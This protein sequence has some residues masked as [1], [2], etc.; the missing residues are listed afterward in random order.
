MPYAILNKSTIGIYAVAEDDQHRD[1]FD[2]RFYDKISIPQSNFND[3]VLG[4]TDII[5]TDNGSTFSYPDLKNGPDPYELNET[6]FNSR[7]SDLQR[8]LN[9][10][11]ANNPDHP[12]Y[13]RAVNYLDS[14]KNLN[15]DNITFPLSVT[16]EEYMDQ[17]NIDFLHPYQIR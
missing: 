12:I 17:Q 14:L 1:A 9:Q 13:N 5:T 2:S 10:F 4:K 6:E 3:V 16:F 15:L 11:I 7:L 8:S